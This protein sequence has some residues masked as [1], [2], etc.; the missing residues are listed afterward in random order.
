MPKFEKKEINKQKP[1]QEMATI[2]ICS[3]KFDSIYDYKK[4]IEPHEFMQIM[5]TDN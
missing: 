2:R 1:T 5:L 3:F 4:F